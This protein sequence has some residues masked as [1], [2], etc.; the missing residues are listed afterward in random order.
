MQNFTGTE[1]NRVDCVSED[2]YRRV[3]TVIKVLEAVSRMSYKSFYV[4]DYHKRNFPYVSENPL[5]LC[6]RQP[7]EVKEMGYAF[8]YDHVPENELSMLLEINRAGFSL[9]NAFSPEDRLKSTLS[10]D[11]HIQ[12]PN[13]RILINHNLSPIL[14]AG[15]G[16]IWL[17]ACMVSLSSHK[18]A[19]NVE[20]RSAG[21]NECLTY[22][23]DSLN[24][25]PKGNIILNER[26]KEILSYSS[27]GLTED[28]VADKLFLARSTVKYHK[29]NLFSKLNVTNMIEALSFAADSKLI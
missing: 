21:K 14:L 3:D 4:V 16:D 24:W 25:E 10:F 23:L 13:S 9:M 12:Y 19:G 18:Q 28:E 17:A 7:Q 22:S 15:N 27:Q 26:E 2:D 8:Y 11:F 5:F 20:V 1:I 6:G 29:K